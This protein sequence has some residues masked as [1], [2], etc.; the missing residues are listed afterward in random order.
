MEHPIQTTVE[1]GYR[2]LAFNRPD[3]LNAFNAQMNLEFQLALDAA[4]KDENCR[5]LIITANGRAFTAG[6]DLSALQAGKPDAAS[7]RTRETLEKLYNPI[8][9]ALANFRMPVICAINGVA[10]GAGLNI[11]LGC[12]IVL[13]ARSAKLLQPFA[14]IGLIPDAGGTWHLPRLVGAARARGLAMLAEPI[15]AEQAEAM[16]LIWRAVDDDQLMA[17]AVV[18]AV[19]LAAMPTRALTAIRKA[20]DAAPRNTFAQQLDLE[21][22]V[23]AR[24]AAE[25][26]HRE[27]VAAFLQKRPAKFTGTA[28]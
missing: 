28:S 20:I 6:Q 1:D 16:G 8:V 26:D 22:D 7:E 25:P 27:G 4:D 11:A 23:Q 21:C 9:L 15:T 14:R 17:E 24:L 2:I 13:A 18:L 3:K 5:A 12:D 19:K 10:A